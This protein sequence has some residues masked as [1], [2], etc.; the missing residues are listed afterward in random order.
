[1]DFRLL[2]TTKTTQE[3]ELPRQLQPKDVVLGTE[4]VAG[5]AGR[6]D[7]R[8]QS[9]EAEAPESLGHPALRRPRPSEAPWPVGWA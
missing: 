5:E 8:P 6:R 7:S 2:V 9:L 1:M 3:T 4:R